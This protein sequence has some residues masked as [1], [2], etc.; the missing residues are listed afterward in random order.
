LALLETSP[1]AFLV[2]LVLAG[3]L[4]PVYAT[5]LLFLD[6]LEHEPPWLL[7]LALAWGPVWRR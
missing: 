6:P 4:A 3:I 1:T 2:G 5:Y 7:G